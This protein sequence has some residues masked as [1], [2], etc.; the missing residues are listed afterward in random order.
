MSKIYR[1]MILLLFVLITTFFVNGAANAQWGSALTYNGSNQYAHHG[2]VLSTLTDSITLEAWTK[3]KGT[4]GDHQIIVYNGNTGTSGYGLYLDVSGDQL[5][6]LVGGLDSKMATDGVG[7]P[8][9]L[10]L[11]TWIHLAAVRNAGTWSLY[12]NGTALTLT[13]GNHSAPY[14]PSGNFMVGGHSAGTEGFKGVVDEVRFSR[15]VRYTSNFVLPSAPFTADTNTIALY[16]FDENTGSI[17]LDAS[18][19]NDTLTLV[20]SP[21]WVKPPW[22]ATLTATEVTDTSALLHATVDPNGSQDVV[23]FDWGTSTSYGSASANDTVDDPQTA[24]SFNG[25]QYVSVGYSASLDITTA[26]SLEAWIYPTIGSQDGGIIEKTIGGAVN[27]QYLLFI[28]GWLGTFRLIQGTGATNVVTNDPIPINQWTHIAATWDYVVGTM[29]IFI[30]GVQQNQTAALPYALDHGDGP[31]LIGKLGSG[32]YPFIGTIDEVRVWNTALP[33]SVIKEWSH[34]NVTSAHPFYANLQAYWQFNEGAGGS[35]SDASGNGNTGSLSGGASWTSGSRSMPV[36][37][38]LSGL[39]SST[40]YHYR[41]A[42]T[43]TADSC[44]GFDSSFTT[45]GALPIELATL[46]ANLVNGRNVQL[47]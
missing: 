32:A 12:A 35:A 40:T 28:E 31:T 14:T 33:A 25:S 46:T 26:L 37:A 29:K 27:K 22:V 43:N 47:N 5:G 20:N 39:S 18:A 11:N 10:P 36:W 44:K 2:T 45:L 24:L 38:E 41:I 30:N 1:G 7:H 19:N 3:W 9:V 23:H 8:Y 21:V 16:H 4:T 42:A 34:R 15:S 17:A 6:V 13:E